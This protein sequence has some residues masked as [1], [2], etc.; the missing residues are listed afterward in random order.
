MAPHQGR[1]RL[2]CINSSKFWISPT[3]VYDPSPSSVKLC[4]AAARMISAVSPEATSGTAVG[5]GVAGMTGGAWTCG[6]KGGKKKKK[7]QALY[8][9]REGH[10]HRNRGPSYYNQYWG[11]LLTPCFSFSQ[12]SL[13]CHRIQSLKR[14]FYARKSIKKYIIFLDFV[15]LVVSVSF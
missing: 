6:E 2:T 7:S 10:T 1:P 4:S 15:M 9:G 5:G 3:G 8:S 14:T 12:G 11:T 13:H